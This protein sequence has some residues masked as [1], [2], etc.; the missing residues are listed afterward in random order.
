MQ[1]S[2]SALG[3]TSPVTV[4]NNRGLHLRVETCKKKNAK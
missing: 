3:Y 1:R 2:H 4:K